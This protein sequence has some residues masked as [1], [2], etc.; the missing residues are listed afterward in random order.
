MVIVATPRG[1][2]LDPGMA[3]AAGTA[4]LLTAVDYAEAPVASGSG[5]V[6]I[7]I[8]E[9]RASCQAGCAPDVLGLDCAGDGPRVVVS[10]KTGIVPD[11]IL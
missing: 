2:K 8:V 5:R 3:R 9:P 1:T 6:G 7:H 11:G 4:T 10:R